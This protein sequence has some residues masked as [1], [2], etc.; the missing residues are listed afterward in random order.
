MR[1]LYIDLDGTFLRTDILLESLFLVIKKSPR[2][3][4][5]LP[6]W[7]AN[8][9]SYLKRRLAL[10]SEI[11]Y[12]SLPVNEAVAG[13][14]ATEKQRGRRLILATASDRIHAEGVARAHEGLFDDI[15]ASD[16][17]LNLKGR[18]KLAAI[19]KRD[20][21]FAYIGDARAD[22]CILASATE[23]YLA[24]PTRSLERERDDWDGVFLDRKK[25]PQGWLK[26]LRL[27]QS[28]KNL[29]V[30]LPLFLAP[31]ERIADSIL[32]TFIAFFA[33]CFLASGTYI[34]N[35][36]FD[37][38]HD[39]KHPKKRSRPLAAGD[40]SIPQAIAV[41]FALVI[42]G[43]VAAGMVGA[44]LFVVLVAYL[45]TTVAYSFLL[46]HYIGIDVFT[47]ASLFTLRIFAGGEAADLP[48]SFWILSFSMLVFLS[49]ALV[50]RCAELQMLIRQGDKRTSGR[51]YGVEDYPLLQSF[52]VAAGMLSV[53]VF[54]FYT[55]STAF[56]N[57][58]QQ[59]SFVWL[60]LPALSY[61]IFRMWIKTQR[62]EMD[63]D[64]IIYTMTDRGSLVAVAFVGLMFL[65]ERIK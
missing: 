59:P 65:L 31:L 26:Q 44:D 3:L 9:R 13:F 12:R 7:L 41:M 49:L 61:W 25:F 48:L 5:A 11:D 50:K 17:G 23:R 16:P 34:L 10:A 35:D 60:A 54:A 58:Y 46:K 47:L 55:Q 42:A 45:I 37:L 33:F 63:S 51:D 30:F 4:L 56:L 1:P 52:G 53:L 20:R 36:L 43:L 6:V 8:G 21:D 38:E 14:L 22:L 62:G 64:P 24:N 18:H 40:L 57:Q 27:H 2:T 29:L 15:I 19:Q 39:R 32:P 28:L